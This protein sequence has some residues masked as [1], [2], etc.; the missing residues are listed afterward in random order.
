MGEQYILLILRHHQ[1]NPPG[2]VDLDLDLAFLLRVEGLAFF[3]VN[4]LAAFLLVS[5]EKVK[6]RPMA[7]EKL[8][9]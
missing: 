4:G 9:T 2:Q 6:S 7:T 1:L 3:L 5:K 8:K